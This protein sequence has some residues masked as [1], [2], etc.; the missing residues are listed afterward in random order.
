M[1]AKV[2][3]TYSGVDILKPCDWPSNTQNLDYMFVDVV[4]M[5]TLHDKQLVEVN[6][7]VTYNIDILK[8]LNLTLVTF[9]LELVTV[10]NSNSGSFCHIENP[11]RLLDLGRLK[12]PPSSAH[13]SILL[14]YL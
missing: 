14:I 2:S 10:V 5:Y 1:Q 12:A 7:F 9:H 13:R 3:G 11:V 6:Q 8:S 4:A